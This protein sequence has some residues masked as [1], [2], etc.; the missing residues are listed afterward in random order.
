LT[1]RLRLG[2]LDGARA[3]FD[4]IAE[5]P[6]ER[7]IQTFVQRLNRATTTLGSERYR[8]DPTARAFHTD[9]ADFPQANAAQP[10]PT[11]ATSPH[12]H[13]KPK[14][15]PRPRCLVRRR[16]RRRSRPGRECGSPSGRPQ[17]RCRKSS[18]A[19]STRATSTAASTAF[20]RTYAPS[21]GSTG[22][23]TELSMAVADAPNALVVGA[24]V[25]QARSSSPIPST[26][27]T[28]GAPQ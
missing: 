19:T 26:P 21:K 28:A 22:I 6:A 3:T 23:I 14:R 13:G 12:Q 11:H 20:R 10:S 15:E 17:V 2:Q 18:T 8:N 27:N 4:R 16:R 25:R 24:P 1:A 7:R 9:M 5:L